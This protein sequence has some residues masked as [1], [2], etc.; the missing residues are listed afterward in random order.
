MLVDFAGAV[1]PQE[2][3]L[4]KDQS[5]GESKALTAVMNI[6]IDAVLNVGGAAIGGEQKK[7]GDSFKY[8]AFISYSHKD[9]TAAD[10]LHK[11]LESYRVPKP[12]VGSPGRDGPVPARLFPVFR[13]REEVP[14]S[15][16]LGS[17][18]R[19]ALADSA[20]LLVICSP[21]SVASLWVSEEILHF[22]RL[23]RA[24]R[25]LAIIV[26]GEP[27]TGDERECFPEALKFHVGNDG[28][29][30]AQRVEPIAADS[31]PEGDGRDNALLK[32][33]AGILGVGFDQ[34][35]QRE[36]EAARRRAR[37]A[38]TIAASMA[39]LA[40]AALGA[41]SL[42][43]LAS[44]V[45]R[46][47]LEQAQIAQSQVI[48]EK[49]LAA[50]PE[51]AIPA[52]LEALPRSVA[53]PDRP[54]L[55]DVA[56]RLAIMLDLA[57]NRREITP[58]FSQPIQSIRFQ[59]AQP[60]LLSVSGLGPSTVG[61]W[62]VHSGAARFKRSFPD[63]VLS[64]DVS[65]DGA[66]VAV[67][68]RRSGV[69]ITML[70]IDGS[71]RRPLRIAASRPQWSASAAVGV[72]QD[73]NLV[74]VHHA[75]QGVQLVALDPRD[76]GILDVG[77]EACASYGT[78]ATF[79]GASLALIS[80][81]DGTIALWRVGAVLERLTTLKGP[82]DAFDDGYLLD[83]RFVASRSGARLAVGPDA[84][85]K[86]TL[87]RLGDNPAQ[88]AL[89][90]AGRSV[91]LMAFP[92]DADELLVVDDN[93]DAT[94][95]GANGRSRTLERRASAPDSVGRVTHAGLAG[96]GEHVLLAIDSGALEV[97][98]WREWRRVAQIDDRG[99]GDVVAMTIIG[100]SEGFVLVRTDGTTERRRAADGGLIV[101][102]RTHRKAE[103]IEISADGTALVIDEERGI[104]VWESGREPICGMVDGFR[105]R[106]LPM[107][108]KT[109]MVVDLGS[110]PR[111][112]AVRDLS[113]RRALAPPD[114]SWSPQFVRFDPSGRRIA[115]SLFGRSIV[116][117]DAHTYGVVLRTTPSGGD[118]YDIAFDPSGRYLVRQNVRQISVFDTA[119]SS[120]DPIWTADVNVESLAFKDDL[121]FVGVGRDGTEVFAIASGERR[122]AAAPPRERGSLQ[123]MAR[124][125]SAVYRDSAGFS[126]WQT[127]APRP[128]SRHH[129]GG[130]VGFL[131]T[132]ALTPDGSLVALAK[133]T[134][135]DATIRIRPAAEE[136]S[137]TTVITDLAKDDPLA[138]AAFSADGGRIIAVTKA[139]HVRWI[140]SASGAIS[141]GPSCNCGT[142]LGVFTGPNDRALIYGEK[143]IM[144]LGD[145]PKT[146]ALPENVGG[147][148]MVDGQLRYIAFDAAPYLHLVTLATGDIKP[149]VGFSQD[150]RW[151]AQTP[152]AWLSNDGRR[153]AYVRGGLLK[154]FDPATGTERELMSLPAD[155]R[156]GAIAPGGSAMAL[157]LADDTMHVIDL[158][159]GKTRYV[160]TRLPSVVR[161]DFGG[162][163]DSRLLIHS[164]QSGTIV[165]SAKADR[166]L[167]RLGGMGGG[168]FPFEVIEPA[169]P[170]RYIGLSSSSDL[171]SGDGQAMV[172]SAPSFAP[173]RM[174]PLERQGRETP[175]LPGPLKGPR[176]ATSRDGK[177]A[178][179]YG[180]GGAPNLMD[181][182]LRDPQS[183]IDAACRQ[184]IR[185]LSPAELAAFGVIDELPS[186]AAQRLLSRLPTFMT[187]VLTGPVRPPPCGP[188]G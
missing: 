89:N 29:L 162:T 59:T 157:A 144:V 92:G 74:V 114:S 165:A 70:A 19:G 17:E 138:A 151:L 69:P 167:G 86:I 178:L 147:F 185:R 155:L 135:T 6:R 131:A 53:R 110:G 55:P 187:S 42:A 20:C 115:V 183:L 105:R 66:T 90:V 31:R 4:R 51:I 134:S 18:L 40:L 126:V 2:F 159:T 9:R 88:G 62:D 37:V 23:G 83:R 91:R 117:L 96:D 112:L 79:P 182:Q 179:L 8:R 1:E 49:A 107:A 102:A 99:A 168:P 130:V 109:S 146:I 118:V 85:E 13:D 120:P 160:T 65:P 47:R 116:I 76:G 15:A 28:T 38:R 78:K 152:A 81:E 171:V 32:T 145:T 11:G 41:G 80:C 153:L 63:G 58:E 176:I 73:G 154:L 188:A 172:W 68:E 128:A 84:A 52:L 48:S 142:I 164:L 123:T 7:M 56:G 125:G 3:A 163:D 94:I 50:R 100:P 149:V 166:V 177:R 150:L 26:D 5:C 170:E 173:A 36:L 72:A 39:M 35:K 43:W 111:V 104:C 75:N 67:V 113:V 124:N 133:M 161:L 121:L 60:L 34:L 143:A 93:G 158:D 103:G 156:V 10:W 122:P 132:A 27:N 106:L 186:S 12:L 24:D 127:N 30:T 175:I 108:D 180:D 169:G 14:A 16:D 98:R 77:D 181:L 21:R 82:K 140:D 22:K 95:V 141:K 119:G 25:V 148:P 64:A 137:S 61:L 46:E 174:L 139:G 45:A 54:Y 33:I 129:T 71:P 57:R 97:W 87:F 101:T 136:R 44:T 184:V